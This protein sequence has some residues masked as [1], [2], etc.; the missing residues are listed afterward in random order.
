MAYTQ[1]E[2]K[3]MTYYGN[4]DNPDINNGVHSWYDANG[5]TWCL[6]CRKD[7]PLQG[8]YEVE[9][10]YTSNLVNGKKT[11]VLTTNE[12]KKGH[13]SAEGA[14]VYETTKELDTTDKNV[15]QLLTMVGKHLYY[16]PPHGEIFKVLVTS[17]K[18]KTSKDYAEVTV[19]MQLEEV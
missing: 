13:F 15:D 5:N 10:N 9:I 4:V 16:R 8:D 7:N 11:Q 2:S 1:D 6:D 12:I 17:V 3:W 18:P 19:D 14:V